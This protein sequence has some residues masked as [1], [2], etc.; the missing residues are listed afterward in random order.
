LWHVLA[1]KLGACGWL[2]MNKNKLFS[3][4]YQVEGGFLE[5]GVWFAYAIK[6]RE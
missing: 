2:G 1:A 3:K 6:K 4:P 5:R